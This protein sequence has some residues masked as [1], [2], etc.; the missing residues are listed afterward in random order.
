MNDLTTIRIYFEYGQKVK[1]LPFWKR[2]NYD[3]AT[4]IIKKAKLQGLDQ[5]INFSVSKGYFE[6]QK[7]N[8]GN[9]EI[10][11]FN[12]PHIIEITDSEEK[13]NIFLHQEKEFLKGIKILIV[14]NEVV[15]KNLST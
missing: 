12:H 5:I 2:L 9:S 14:K 7:I 8:W 15:L 4:E 11:H 3:F 10:K 13:L 1:N 6:K